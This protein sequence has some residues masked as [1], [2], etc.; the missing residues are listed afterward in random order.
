MSEV[1]TVPT[2]FLREHAL[3]RVC[4]ATGAREDVAYE[5]VQA[6]DAGAAGHVAAEVVLKVVL[7]VFTGL[8][9][10]VVSTGVSQ[11]S[12]ASV[13][14]PLGREVSATVARH[15]VIRSLALVLGMLLVFPAIMT[16]GTA[17]YGHRTPTQ[18]VVGAWGLV[19]GLGALGLLAQHLLCVAP[20]AVTGRRIKRSIELTVPSSEAAAAFRTAV[21]RA[22]RERDRAERAR[23]RSEA[24]RAAA[25]DRAKRE[26][27]D[28]RVECPCCGTVV[29][30]PGRYAGRRGRCKPCGNEYRVPQVVSL[31]A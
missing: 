10:G 3:P 5:V 13:E 20:L 18:L 16:I 28:V 27:P 17:V 7:G 14:V 12:A 22:E 6:P 4:A 21:A 1:V 2:W 9:F 31:A 25:R 15:R 8:A 19:Y 23:E 24:R 26:L 29:R 11:P 30:V